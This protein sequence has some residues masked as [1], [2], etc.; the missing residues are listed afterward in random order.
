MDSM[1]EYTSEKPQC[2]EIGF[3]RS[4]LGVLGYFRFRVAAGEGGG[5]ISPNCRGW[6]LAFGATEGSGKQ[7]RFIVR[8]I[9]PDNFPFLSVSVD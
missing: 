7:C 5:E 6:R 1:G 3:L 4:G 9:W 2:Q 8:H